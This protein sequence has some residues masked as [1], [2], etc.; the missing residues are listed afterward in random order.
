MR[1]KFSRPGS[2]MM[3]RRSCPVLALLAVAAGLAA[4]VNRP[5]PASC[6]SA[7]S[8]FGLFVTHEC[9]IGFAFCGHQDACEFD[10]CY[11]ESTATEGYIQ[12]CV[13]PEYCGWFPGY[14]PPGYPQCPDRG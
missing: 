13:A 2:R 4:I 12:S 10:Q 14:N 7:Y 8:N 6:D 11:C 9:G 1:G 3:L 5:A